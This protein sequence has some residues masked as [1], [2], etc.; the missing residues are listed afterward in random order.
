MSGVKWMTSSAG[1]FASLRSPVIRN[2]Y[3]L[4]APSRARPSEF[5]PTGDVLAEG[6]V[7]VVGDDEVED[8]KLELAGGVWP[9]P[10]PPTGMI[11]SD[12]FSAF[13]PEPVRF[14]EPIQAAPKL[15]IL[16]KLYRRV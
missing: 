2:G 9:S 15:A 3:K 12:F 6:S 14:G 13:P 10:E 1:M 5:D 8:R 7:G 11:E 16:E 4:T